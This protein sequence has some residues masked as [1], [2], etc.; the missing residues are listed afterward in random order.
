MKIDFIPLANVPTV[1]SLTDSAKV[2][3][4]DSGEVKKTAKSNIGGGGGG[5]DESPFSSV[6]VTLVIGSGLRAVEY[7]GSMNYPEPNPNSSNVFPYA[8]TYVVGDTQSDAPE[9][10]ENEI[11]FYLPTYNGVGYLDG[12]FSGFP[13]S[14]SQLSSASVSLSGD[15]VIDKYPP[16]DYFYEMIKITGECTITITWGT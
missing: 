12:N 1:E 7:Y 13:T 8:G 2:L 3:V 9:E 11:T 14:G 16:T 15:A 10:I 4:V 5:G 6:P